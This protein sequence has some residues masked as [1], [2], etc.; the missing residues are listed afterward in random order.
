MCNNVARN[1][2]RSV[3]GG[4]LAPPKAAAPTPPPP[5]PLM[6]DDG[7][8]LPTPAAKAAAKASPPEEGEGPLCIICRAVMHNHEAREAIFCGHTFHRLCLIE[9]RIC[10]NKG[11]Q[12]CPFRCRPDASSSLGDLFQ[13]CFGCHVLFVAC[14]VTINLIVIDTIRGSADGGQPGLLSPAV[15]LPSAPSAMAVVP[16]VGE[17]EN[18]DEE[19]EAAAVVNPEDVQAAQEEMAANVFH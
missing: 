5:R 9:W 4:P 16:A 11:P 15:G 1:H 14:H 12:D 18:P 17:E 6:S 10:A 8:M 19:T 3:Q 2:L 7:R 13:Q